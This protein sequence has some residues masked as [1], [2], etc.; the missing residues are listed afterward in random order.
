MVDDQGGVGAGEL[1]RVVD[2]VGG[3]VG[4]DGDVVEGVDVDGVAPLGDVTLVV[5]VAQGTEDQS[6][7]QI[8]LQTGGPDLGDEI[9]ESQM[10]VSS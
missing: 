4:L 10:G 1:L 9:R 8:L 3:I 5:A 6:L 2:L 7:L